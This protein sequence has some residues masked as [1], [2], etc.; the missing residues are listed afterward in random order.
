MTNFDKLTRKA[1]E[2]L[3]EAQRIAAERHAAEVD[4][5]H[6]LVALLSDSEGTPAIV[7]RQLG[8]D[9]GQLEKQAVARLDARAKVY[10]GAEP[11]F[12]RE[13]TALIGRAGAAAAKL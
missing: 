10:G 7:L 13:M 8:I 1:Q 12:G 4:A 11:R 6:L 3:V 9:V 2:A 5:E